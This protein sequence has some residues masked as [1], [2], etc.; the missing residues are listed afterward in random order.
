MYAGTLMI[1][2]QTEKKDDDP[3]YQPDLYYYWDAPLEEIY[4]WRD[5]FPN[6]DCM[7]E[8]CFDIANSEEKNNLGRPLGCVP[9]KTL[10][11]SLLKTVTYRLI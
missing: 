11:H 3:N 1:F 6:V 5:A 2:Y 7:C 9:V 4:Y 8:I 10:A